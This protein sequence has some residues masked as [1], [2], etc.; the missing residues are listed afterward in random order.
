MTGRRA[1]VMMGF[2]AGLRSGTGTRSAI[3]MGSA[4]GIGLGLVACFILQ[5]A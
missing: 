2:R 4:L 5:I 1:Q 3:T